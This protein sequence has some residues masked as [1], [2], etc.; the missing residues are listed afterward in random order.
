MPPR[1]T[2]GMP[3]Y[4]AEKTVA[5]AIESLL[6]QTVTDFELV[7]SDNAST[8]GTLEILEH[9]A[10]QDD[11]ITLYRNQQNTGAVANFRKVL[12]L[13]SGEFFMW[14]TTDD[15]WEPNC[16]D[17]LISELAVHP[18]ALVALPAVRMVDT[19]GNFLREV[20][21]DKTVSPNLKSCL[22]TSLT[23]MSPAKVNLFICGLMRRD[24]LARNS[25]FFEMNDSS[26]RMLMGL[27]ALA[28]PFRYVDT[29]LYEKTRD[30]P[31]D[32]RNPN[33]PHGKA[34]AKAKQRWIY[35]QPFLFFCRN[36]PRCRDIPLRNKLSSLVLLAKSI[37]FGA[38]ITSIRLKRR[39]GK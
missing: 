18:E 9:Y 10:R 17:T 12:E 37:V 5:R 24:R 22:E 14:T 27:L 6:A 11:R 15:Y 19:E 26:D 28:F 4:N 32:V 34:I 16:V 31:Y 20:R 35:Y 38:Q 7:I 8:D 25:H 3:V 1:V 39:F 29:V 2:F 30:L 21:F 13:A 23:F 33:D 36:I